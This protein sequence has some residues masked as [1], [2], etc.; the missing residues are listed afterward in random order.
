MF[1]PHSKRTHCTS[2]QNKRFTIGFVQVN[3]RLLV[4]NCG[5]ESHQLKSLLTFHK[6]IFHFCCNSPF[7]EPCHIFE[8]FIACAY[9]DCVLRSGDNMYLVLSAFSFRQAALLASN[10][11]CNIVIVTVIHTLQGVLR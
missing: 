7:P 8:N 10:S 11:F 4:A 6:C 5:Q 2:I 3:F 9:Y 1:F